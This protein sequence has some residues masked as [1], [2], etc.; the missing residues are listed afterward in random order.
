[1][2]QQPGPYPYAAFPRRRQPVF[3]TGP[4]KPGDWVVLGIY[5]ALFVFGAA[6]LLVMIPG[7]VESFRDIESAQFG[8]NLI[9]YV[10]VFTGAMIMAFEALRSS[11]ATFKYHPWAKALMVPGAWLGTLIISAIVLTSMGNPVKSENQLAIEGMTT[12]V[13]FP[14]MFVVAVL[15]GPFVEEYVFRHLLIGKLSAKLNIWVCVVISVVLFTSLHFIG[16]G[17]FDLTSA[18][19]YTTLGVMMSV[20]YVLTGKSLAY[21]FILHAFNNAVALSLAYTLLPLISQ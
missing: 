11:F 18:I 2:H 14:M 9:I 5:L 10:V 4:T 13:P 3:D 19:P 16:A 6:G 15:M 1:M 12:S 21:S 8:V 7:F 17:S 20:A